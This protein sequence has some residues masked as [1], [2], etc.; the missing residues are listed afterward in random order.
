[1]KRLF[2]ALDIPDTIKDDLLA[3]QP[4]AGGGLRPLGREGLHLTLCFLGTADTARVD[5]AVRDVAAAGFSLRFKG[6]GGTR[7]ARGGVLWAGVEPCEALTALQGELSAA[8]RQAGFRTD[9]RAFHPH[10]TLVRCRRGVSRQR[11]ERF[12]QQGE[13]LDLGPARFREFVLFSSDTRPEGAVYRIER[14]YPLRG[15]GDAPPA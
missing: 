15:A 12:L 2:L 6:L 7:P 14:R 3:F 10:V 8:L 1:M 4:A 5:Q 9:S 13:R 11:I